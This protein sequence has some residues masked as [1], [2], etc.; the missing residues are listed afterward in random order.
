MSLLPAATPRASLTR[1]S[2]AIAAAGITEAVSLLGVRGYYRDTMGVPGRNDRAIYDDAFFIVG[3]E[4][5]AA[6]NG[7]TDPGAW[8]TGI[9][10]LKPG[11]WRYKPGQ[12]GITF[13]RPGYPYPAFVQAAP[14]TVARD[15]QGD[16]TGWFGINIHRG[17]H[18]SV[19]SLGCQTVPP[20][21][22]PAFQ[23]LL[24]TVLKRAGQ[25]SFPYRLI[26]VADLP[27]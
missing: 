17:S 7:N 6:F 5:F 22:W 10:D 8:R 12:H 4:T 16:E 19:S 3:P 2:Q 1:V 14:V 18:T 9:A 15:G 20:A 23:E 24:T 11:T 27:S 21:Q 26:D 25:K 13:N